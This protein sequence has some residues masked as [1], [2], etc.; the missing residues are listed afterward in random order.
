MIALTLV[1]IFALYMSSLAIR[2]LIEDIL[3][4]MG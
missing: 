1:M 3:S 4:I 2:G